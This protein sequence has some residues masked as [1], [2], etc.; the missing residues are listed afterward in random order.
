MHPLTHPPAHPHGINTYT[1]SE[2]FRPVV[3][4]AAVNAT[5]AISVGY[6]GFGE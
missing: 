4:P 2:A 5:Y 3:P 1:H 6:V